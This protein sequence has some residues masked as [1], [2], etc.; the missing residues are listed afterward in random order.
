MRK[1]I[2]DELSTWA[3]LGSKSSDRK[4]NSR[5][6]VQAGDI[7]DPVLSTV[8]K[9]RMGFYDTT[10][11]WSGEN[12]QT[13]VENVISTN[14]GMSTSHENST[15]NTQSLILPDV[16]PAIAK[17]SF[18]GC[19]RIRSIS[20]DQQEHVNIGNHFTNRNNIIMALNSIATFIIFELNVETL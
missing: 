7:S 15:L 14:G 4:K 12:G 2:L 8:D 16:T 19:H 20:D 17:S 9:R 6:F 13:M 5:W 1:S 3:H 11:A 10:S 18:L